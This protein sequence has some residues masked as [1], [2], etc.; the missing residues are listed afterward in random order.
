MQPAQSHDGWV[1]SG[2]CQPQVSGC[3]ECC[4]DHGG[5][6]LIAGAALYVIKPV[7]TSNPAFVTTPVDASSPAI[8]TDFDYSYTISPAIWIGYGNNSM[9]TRPLVPIR[10][11]RTTPRRQRRQHLRAF[12]HASRLGERLVDRRR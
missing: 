10:S 12:G 1:K 3:N 8:Q 7:W 11:E 2:C 4:N 9:R 5:G 6:S